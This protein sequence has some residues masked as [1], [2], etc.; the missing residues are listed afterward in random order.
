M[1]HVENNNKF[2]VN[3]A[4]FSMKKKKKKLPTKTNSIKNTLL[5]V[6]KINCMKI[7]GFAKLALTKP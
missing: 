6:D 4:K 5:I 2:H 7:S 3:F 1:T